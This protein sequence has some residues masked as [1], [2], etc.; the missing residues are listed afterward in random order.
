MNNIKPNMT[1]MR[2]REAAS[3]FQLARTLERSGDYNGARA[4]LSGVWSALGQRPA[5]D[6][7]P[8]D[9]QAEG[10]LRV[11]TLA[12]WIG[13]AS[14][15][16][17]TQE[18]AKDLITEATRIFEQMEIS[19]KV[20][21]AQTDLAICYWRLGAFSEAR[22]LFT[23]AEENARNAENKLRVLVNRS[24]VEISCGEFE[25]ALYLLDRASPLVEIVSDRSA[26]GRY[27]IQRALAFKKLGGVEN[28]DR[29]LIQYSAASLHLTEA[30]D[31]RYLA[32]VENN[33]ALVHLELG[34]QEE[35]LSH[36][37]RARAL[38][39]KLRESGKVAEVNEA[40]A[41]ALIAKG[42]FAEAER[43][44]F[45]AI[46]TLERGDEHSLLANAHI[47]RGLALARMGNDKA[48]RTAFQR[49]A[50]V[51]D[52]AGDRRAAA[53]AYLAIVEELS[54]F[55]AVEEAAKIF[56]AADTRLD[57][58]DARVAE[59]VRNG[60]RIIAERFL[61]SPDERLDGFLIGGSI[62]EE[63]HHLEAVLIK[64]AL[65]QTNGSVTR[66]AR[67]LGLTYQGLAWT[68]ENRQR[69]ILSSRKPRHHRRK[70][71]IKSKSL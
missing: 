12:G 42:S 2:E 18:F 69:Q 59:R 25:R 11:G 47:T 58:L 32:V 63:L 54:R 49:A 7:L 61:Q 70:S 26:T 5:V 50:D 43:A 64:R 36:L 28:L 17:G 56:L 52:E 35:A 68:L 19:E 51:A 60:A 16:A 3:Q 13:T 48:A 4:A 53:C 14:Q 9:L 38:F 15:I 46:T 39:V 20:A 30:G 33:I 55:L 27:H 45:D 23:H 8:A 71:I 67:M 1:Q 57:T 40:R 37:D 6:D 41:Q 62:E 24:A 44:A 21:E 29:A 31:S 22:V 66:A 10:L 65:D 34:R